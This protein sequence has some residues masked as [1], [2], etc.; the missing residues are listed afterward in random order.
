MSDHC[1]AIQEE[2]T[3]QQALHTEAAVVPMGI[4]LQVLTLV[5]HNPHKVLMVLMEHQGREGRMGQ[6]QGAPQV[7][8]MEVMGDSLTEGFMDTQ[9]LQVNIDLDVCCMLLHSLC[10]WKLNKR[11]LNVSRLLIG[12]HCLSPSLLV[13]PL[14]LTL[15]WNDG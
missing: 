4:L 13:F 7:G 15:W 9:P 3:H 1:R 12:S 2:E 10:F 6:D 14:L 8:H 11:I 5:H